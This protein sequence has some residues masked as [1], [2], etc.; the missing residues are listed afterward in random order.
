MIA[1]DLRKGHVAVVK[2]T[3]PRLRPGYALIRMSLAG[4][5]NTDLELRRGYYGFAGRPGHEFAGIVEA[6]HDPQWLGKRVV[7]EINIGCER[8]DWCERRLSR[9]CPKRSV[10]GIVKHPGAFAE[11]LTLPVRNLRTVPK[12]LTDEQAVFT[13][14]VAAACEI[15]DQ[16]KIDPQHRVA[17]LGDGKLGLLIG[18]VLATTGVE[19]TLVGRHAEKLRLAR[20]WGLRTKL[21]DQ[22]QARREFDV[23]VDA[24][25]ASEGLH[26]AIAMTKPRGTVVMKSTVHDRTAIDIASVIV[27]EITLVGSRCGRFEP[28]LRLLSRGVVQVAPL[29]EQIYPLSEAPAAF[30]HAERKGARKILLRGVA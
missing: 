17:V 4:I 12:A 8:C 24:T 14:P 26:A 20:G 5:C 15:L 29:I 18:Q 1:V 10:L 19:V 25:G 22:A 3:K 21:A 27:P 23:V 7:G 13:E 30:A 2:V 9:H 11:W 16:V 6:C 28:A